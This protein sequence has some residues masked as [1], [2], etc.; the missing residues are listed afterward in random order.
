MY[1]VNQ[2]PVKL[3][4]IANSRDNVAATRIRS[5]EN[6]SNKGQDDYL[7]SNER[8]N[9]RHAPDYIY[10]RDAVN[11]DIH[12]N[13]G[14]PD[15]R[16][17]GYPT[18]DI[19]SR[20]RAVIKN[21]DYYGP[22]LDRN[23]SDYI[24]ERRQNPNEDILYGRKV[25][26]SFDVQDQ[27]YNNND[28]EENGRLERTGRTDRNRDKERIKRYDETRDKRYYGP[29]DVRNH[30]YD[31]RDRYYESRTPTSYKIRDDLINKNNTSRRKLDNRFDRISMISGDRDRYSEREKDSIA[32]GADEDASVVSAR[33]NYLRVVKVI[34]V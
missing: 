22:N 34:N 25:S 12:R 18:Q 3:E 20:S 9:S 28:S 23:N 27:R 30:I 16:G 4:S 7:T 32:S 26:R 29:R 8:N 10:E 19:A 5:V 31:E 1:D 17:R 13:N 6:V 2:R 15:Y 24:R 14:R 21:Y 33:S 11:Y